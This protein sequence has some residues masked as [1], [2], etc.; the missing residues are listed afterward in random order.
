MSKDLI[1]LEIV[2][3][4]APHLSSLQA[5]GFEIYAPRDFTEIQELVRQ[6]GREK[7][8]PMMSIARNDFTLGSAFWLFLMVDGK[9]VGGCAA[10]MIDLRD[11]SFEHY[12]RRT[13]KEQYQCEEDPI[14]SVAAPVAKEIKGRVVYIGELELKS[15]YRGRLRSLTAFTRVM[16]ALIAVKWP[17]F[18]WM[19][20]FVPLDHSKLTG[21]YGFTWQMPYAIRWKKPAP[22]GRLDS[23][24]L[25]GLPKSHF[26]HV[27]SSD[28]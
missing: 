24:W 11:E 9:C 23:H 8:T 27:W 5:D 4:A 15:E 7:Q 3:R 22:E 6:T 18:D 1:E 25:I 2:R 14:E 17:D 10:H 26:D 16:Q 20:A 28:L 19:Y 12:L 13:S 21:L